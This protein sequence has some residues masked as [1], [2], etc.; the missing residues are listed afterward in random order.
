MTGFVVHGHIWSM[1]WNNVRFIVQSIE[2]AL[3]NNHKIHRT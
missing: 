2:L 3:N 1:N